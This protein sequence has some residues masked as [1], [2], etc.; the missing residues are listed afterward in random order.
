MIVDP[1]IF[2]IWHLNQLLTDARAWGRPHP[3]FEEFAIYPA[4]VNATIHQLI[5]LMSAAGFA[6]AQRGLRW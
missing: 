6:K 5:E 4:W 2:D 3:Q 1:A